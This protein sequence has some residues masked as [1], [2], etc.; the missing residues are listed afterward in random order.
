MGQFLVITLSGYV[1]CIL[2]HRIWFTTLGIFMH[3]I[4]NTGVKVKVEMIVNKTKGRTLW[5][6]KIL[7][8]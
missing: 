3:N 4:L 7:I 8:F 6:V 2:D 5:S 1:S